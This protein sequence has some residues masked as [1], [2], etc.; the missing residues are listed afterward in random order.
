MI[1]VIIPVYNSYD[2]IC[3]SLASLSIQTIKD[4]VLVTIVDDDSEKD[5]YDQIDVFKND[6]NIN[7][8]KL[9]SNRGPGAAREYGLMNTMR[10]YIVFLDADD[11]FMDCYSLERLYNEINSRQLDLVIGSDLE[12]GKGININNYGNLHS[13]I[14]RRSHIIN[15][16][17]HFNYSRYSEDNSFN[18]IVMNTTSKVLKMDDIFYIYRYNTNSITNDKSKK[19][20]IMMSYIFNM[21]WT[22]KELEKRNVYKGNINNIICFCYVYVYKQ[23]KEDFTDTD[24][25]K[26]YKLCYKLEDTFEEYNNYHCDDDIFN[27]ISNE[28]ICSNTYKQSIIA[29]FNNFRL[30]FKR[31]DNSD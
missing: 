3:D 6:L 14:Y 25:S 16:N 28:I 7:Y 17:I 18:Q 10:E 20:K 13:K 27:L 30:N 9:D 23:I 29:D 1:D 31:G 21:I 2:T 24:Y 19:I 8:L 15:N 4:D 26:L 11:Q 22:V 12:E 5:Y